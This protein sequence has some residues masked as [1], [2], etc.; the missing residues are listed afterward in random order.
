MLMGAR[1]GGGAS[2]K[3]RHSP[4]RG[5]K[6]LVSRSSWLGPNLIRIIPII[7]IWIRPSIIDLDCLQIVHLLFY[8]IKKLVSGIEYFQIFHNI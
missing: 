6:S 2:L 1:K 5:K 3:S 8:L 7:N 4:P